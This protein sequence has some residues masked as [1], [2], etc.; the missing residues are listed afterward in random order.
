MVEA[1]ERR[2]FLPSLVAWLDASGV[3]EIVLE[4]GY[5]STVGFGRRE[6]EAASSRV[7]RWPSASPPAW[8]R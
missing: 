7:R 4:H 5:G 3:G 8:K 6:Y 2:A 1:G